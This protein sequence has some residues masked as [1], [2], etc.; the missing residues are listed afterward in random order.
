MLADQGGNEVILQLVD[1]YMGLEK[2]ESYEVIRLTLNILSTLSLTGVIDEEEAG[3]RLR[4]F[5]I[6]LRSPR[7]R[8]K[9]PLNV[10]SAGGAE[11]SQPVAK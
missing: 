11:R 4:S 6:D 8:A 7:S 9:N 2:I 1:S 5:D 10:P 3:R